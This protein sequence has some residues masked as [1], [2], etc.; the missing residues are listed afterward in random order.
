MIE[1]ILVR[2]NR[3]TVALAVRNGALTVMAPLR[4]PKQEIDKLVRSK[5]KWIKG[6]LAQSRATLE[7]REQF[8]LDY[9]GSVLYRGAPH[10]I[11]AREGDRAGFGDGQ[12]LLPPHF[13]PARIKAVCVQ[14]YRRYALDVMIENVKHYAAQMNSWPIDLK[15]NGAKTRWGS[16]SSAGRLNFS[17]RLVMADD[18]V[19]AYVVVHE[20]AHLGMMNHSPKFWAIVE[21]VLPDYKERQARLKTLQQRL[22]AEDWE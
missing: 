5:E 14:C 7:Q 22:G 18:D 17:W 21:G 4:A 8:S 12:F 2:S 13:P 20:L 19:I 15:I 9:G 1:Y 6:K 16:C 3:K 10:T 11:V